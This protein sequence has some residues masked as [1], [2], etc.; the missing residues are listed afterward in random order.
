MKTKFC[1]LCQKE[2]RVLYRVQVKKGKVWIFVCTDCC[3]KVKTE[4]NYRYEVHGKAVLYL[5]WVAKILLFS[6]LTISL[7]L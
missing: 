7:L 6:C 5:Q 1:A 4:P 3:N 2:D